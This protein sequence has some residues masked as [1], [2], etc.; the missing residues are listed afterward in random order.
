[1]SPILPN[2]FLALDF[3]FGPT[4]SLS[5]LPVWVHFQ[6]EPTSGLGPLLVWFHFRFEP[7]VWSK[8]QVGQSFEHSLDAWKSVKCPRI[9]PKMFSTDFI[10]RQQ[11][12]LVDNQKC[13]AEFRLLC[14]KIL[15][16]KEGRQHRILDKLYRPDGTCGLGILN[17]LHFSYVQS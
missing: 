8:L 7:E 13:Q 9:Y 3:R 16:L 6:F 14:N 11:E 15:I 10:F 5:P 17:F 4:S 1:M 12:N 2:Q